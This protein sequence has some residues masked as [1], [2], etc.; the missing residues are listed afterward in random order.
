MATPY[1]GNNGHDDHD[2]AADDGDQAEGNN[3]VTGDGSEDEYPHHY[4][5]PIYTG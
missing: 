4:S 5:A 2:G 1:G 3:N